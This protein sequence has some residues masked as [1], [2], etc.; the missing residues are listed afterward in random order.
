MFDNLTNK[1]SAIMRNITNKGKI[2]EKDIEDIL[3]QIRIALLEADV[4]YKVVKILLD[5]IKQRALLSDFSK[6]ITPGQIVLKIV[7]EEINNVLGSSTARLNISLN[8]PSK[9]ML[10]GLQGSGKTTTAAK[11]ANLLKKEGHLPLLIAA[12]IQRPAAI[13]Q[14]SILA[15]QIDVPIYISSNAKTALDV[16]NSALEHIKK[17]V[18][19]VVIVDTQG[20]LHIDHTMMNELI[21]IKEIL[22]PN[23][24]LL[25]I[26]SM[27]G[28]EAIN[29]AEQFHK[30]L[31]ITGLI[32]TKVDGDARGG[33]AISI[34]Y[35]TGIP[36]KYVGVGEKINALEAFHPDRISSRILGMGDLATLIEKTKSAYSEQQLEKIEKKLRKAE[37]DL[38]DFLQQIKQIQK[39]GSISQILSMIPGISRFHGDID[40]ISETQIKKIEAIILSMTPQERKYPEIINGSRRKRIALGSGTTTKDVNQLLNQFEQVKR[41]SKLATKNKMSQLNLPNIFK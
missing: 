17:S 35:M 1:L 7:F 12:D 2:N 29:I 19:S 3:R 40:G 36:I 16:I 6:T 26:D 22:K 27:L 37:F 13:E 11:L 10:V 15:K 28:Q 18:A 14:L 9:I 24:I 31:N 33:A 25:T 5:Q 21:S 20:R 32:M 39:M 38:E 41:L 23:E 30:N 8:T 34:R 4:N